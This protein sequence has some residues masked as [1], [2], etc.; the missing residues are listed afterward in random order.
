MRF[1]VSVMTMRT[2]EGWFSSSMDVKHAVF[3]LNATSA[4]EARGLAARICEYVNPTSQGWSVPSATE[5]EIPPVD[6]QGVS[7]LASEKRAGEK[8]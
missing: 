3:V 1:A 6:P 4:D 5:A 7:V 8:A 2:R